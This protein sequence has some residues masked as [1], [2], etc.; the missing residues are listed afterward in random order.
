[1]DLSTDS[2]LDL[3]KLRSGA[4]SSISATGGV[5]IL[6]VINY[7]ISNGLC[8]WIIGGR[9]EILV[10]QQEYDNIN[11]TGYATASFTTF[12]NFSA[13]QTFTITGITFTAKASPVGAT[14]FLI[15]AD[16]EESMANLLAKIVVQLAVLNQVSAAL[17]P[18]NPE[19]IVFTAIEPGEIGNHYT[20]STTCSLGT[21]VGF[22]GG[23]NYEGKEFPL[24]QRA[25]GRK[26]RQAVFFTPGSVVGYI[27]I[28]QIAFENVPEPMNGFLQARYTYTPY[29]Q[30]Y[31]FKGDK[32]IFWPQQLGNRGQNL[33]IYYYKR[34]S[35]LVLKAD[36]RT[37]SNYFNI[38]NGFQQ[39][40]INSAIPSSWGIAGSTI[41]V[42]IMEN[43]SPFRVLAEGVTCVVA[44]TT[45]LNVDPNTDLSAIYNGCYINLT[46]KTSYPQIPQELFEVAAQ[47]ASVRLLEIMGDN[48]RYPFA[49]ATLEKMKK[50]LATYIAPRDDSGSMKVISKNALR[51]LM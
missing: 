39:L 19:R 45:T 16:I 30:G 10:A 11:P 51:S 49:L 1:M 34:P 50:E 28:P 35:E 44:S 31:Y 6:D 14:Q 36:G 29:P 33:R 26:L 15:G 25:M 8:P 48:T 38:S 18:N 22:S 2:L 43:V 13:D 7:Q 5:S 32:I 37:I 42:D 40:L 4:N 24:P 47:F 20:L 23:F 46:G 27:N 9:N 3:T 21:I 12:S 41:K 17:D